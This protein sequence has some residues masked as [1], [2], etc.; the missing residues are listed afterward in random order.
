MYIGFWDRSVDESV[1]KIPKSKMTSNMADENLDLS[2]THFSGIF[3]VVNYES[4]I[5]IFKNSNII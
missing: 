1:V 5:E 3:R 2:E 4:K